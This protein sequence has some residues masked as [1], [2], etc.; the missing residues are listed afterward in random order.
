[1]SQGPEALRKGVLLGGRFEVESV[2]GRGGFGIAYLVNDVVRKD[3]AALKELAPF[4]CERSESGLLDLDAGGISSHRLR[5]SFLEEARLLSRLNL[6]GILP[7]R[8]VFAEN[9]TAYYATD[10]L[11]EAETLERLLLREG[12]MDPA[13]A[14][15]IVF[16][17]LETLEA[18]HAKG[19]LHRDIKPSNIL[20]GPKGQAYLIDFGSAREWHA[21]EATRHTVLYTPGYAPIEQLSE[22]GRR[23]PAT[24]LYG[25][26]ATVY[27]M[28]TGSVPMPSTDR[29]NGAEL[30]PLRSL[31]PDVEPA[32]ASAIESGLSV[33]YHDRPQTVAE[34]RSLLSDAEEEDETESLAAYDAKLLKLQRFGFERRQC[35]ACGGVLEQPRPLRKWGCPVCRDGT[36]RKRDIPSRLCPACQLGALHKRANDKPLAFCPVCRFGQLA[37]RK[38]GFLQRKLFLDCLSC[39]TGFEVL[40]DMISVVGSEEPGHTSAEWRD[41]CERSAEVW[42]C[43][44]C[45][46]QYDLLEDGRW[47]QVTPKP[48]RYHA[49][50]PEE[51][52]RIAAG[53]PPGA[54]NAACDVC[55]ADFFID[56]NRLTLLTTEID[57]HGFGAEHLGRLLDAEDVRWLGVGK[58]SPH[59]G[60]VCI[61]C[62]TELDFDGDYLRLVKTAHRQLIRHI[63]EPKKLVDWHR[64]ALGLPEVHEEQGFRTDVLTAIR[65]AYEDGEIGFDSRNDVSWKGPATKERQ[66]GTLVIAK[67]ELQ[68]GGLIKKWRV[69]ADAIVSVSGNGDVLAIQVGGEEEPTVFELA[70]VELTVRLG[71]GDHAVM[72][73]AESLAR[74]LEGM[75]QPAGAKGR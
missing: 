13:G 73:N 40:D 57:T 33:R 39:K 17:L 25:L 32:I 21:D 10:H 42:V 35:P 54:G 48:K 74:R 7:V 20:V 18:V 16:Q 8:A 44:G 29:A 47:G 50:Y 23:G 12:R 72:L 62:G 31:R 4:G 59:P 43:D 41:I 56:D 53:L 63:G 3:Q 66:S 34:F 27:R 11:A 19:I 28:L 2:L 22:R 69:P 37:Q 26:S 67:G 1:M 49:L 5:Q 15:D 46:A 71:S 24:D 45:E 36:I 38:Q 61:D 51:W 52:A 9:G 14:M 70:P 64:T 30:V 6:P 68:F 75:R 65:Y 58:D 60:Y 55:R